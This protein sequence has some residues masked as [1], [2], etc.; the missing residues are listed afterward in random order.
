M[1]ILLFTGAGASVELGVPAMRMMLE[2]FLDHLKER[3]FTPEALIKIEQWLTDGQH[4]MEQLIDLVDGVEKGLV[5]QRVLGMDVD[6][7]QV[8][9]FGTIR[10]EAEW[11][12]P[13]ACERVQTHWARQLWTPTLRN[14]Q[15]HDAVIATTNYDRSIEVAASQLNTDFD[16]GFEEF[17]TR[18]FAAWRGIDT[19]ENIKLLKL[20]GSTDWYQ[21]RDGPVFKLRHAMPLYG[22]LTL[23]VA[24]QDTPAL[25]SA[26]VLPSREKKI[27]QPPYPDLATEFRTRA[28]RAEVAIFLGTSLRDPDMR[29]VCADCAKYIPTFL[30]SRSG[31]Y[32]NG[33]VPKSAIILKQSASRFLISTLPNFLRQS[34]PDYLKR[35][36]E[37]SEGYT[38]SILEWIVTATDDDRPTEDRC[39]AIEKLASNRVGLESQEVEGLLRCDNPDVQKFA[40][41]LVQDSPDFEELANLAQSMAKEDI[42]SSFD[43]E[44]QL[45]VDLLRETHD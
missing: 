24:N 40:L 17:E 26:L 31:E 4:D 45:L 44:T 43:K 41:G 39:A 7:T 6:D 33:H 38:S 13:H 18:E 28:R 37:D 8:E 1:R 12:V 11:F 14:I 19:L 20:H 30:V 10:Q 22:G 42:G 21:A 3:C 34:E 29:G 32:K 35:Y 15:M 27:T 36:A 23:K 16:D 25:T 9:S 5:Y 2:Q